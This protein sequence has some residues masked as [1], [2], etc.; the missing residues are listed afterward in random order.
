MNKTLVHFPCV[1]RYIYLFDTNC[2]KWRLYHSFIS[3]S[4]H[5]GVFARN[6]HVT[7][8]CFKVKLLKHWNYRILKKA[9]NKYSFLDF[10]I[11]V[12]LSQLTQIHEA[13]DFLHRKYNYS[14]ITCINL[15]YLT[16]HT[17]NNTRHFY[18][19]HWVAKINI[20]FLHALNSL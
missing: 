7:N 10:A 20:Q 4:F 6:I 15:S 8:N 9:T 17:Y 3:F 19:L 16:H 2:T 12:G 5:L 1:L 14:V 18:W 13:T 11:F